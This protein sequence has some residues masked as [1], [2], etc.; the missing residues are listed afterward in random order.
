[1]NTN[2]INKGAISDN[3]IGIGTVSRRMVRE[4]AVELAIINGRFE[5]DVSKAD[6]E[7]ARRELS[8]GPDADPKEAV[9]ESVPESERWNVVPG[10]DGF[11]VP[12]IPGDEDEDDEGRSQTAQLVEQGIAEAEHDQMLQAARESAK[13]D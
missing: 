2:P 4:R 1:M 5:Q 7:Q 8:G 3:F 10:S 6:W 9:L 12:E 13:E 11:Q